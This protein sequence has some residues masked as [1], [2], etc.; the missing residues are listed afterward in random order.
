[1]GRDDAHV[2]SE[3]DVDAMIDTNV[4]G[5]VRV[6]RA[7]VPGMIAR[8]SGD[9]INISRYTQC[10]FACYWLAIYEGLF[11]ILS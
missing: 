6:T 9:I 8:G 1:M 11:F 4:K 10:P 2:V 5:L 3:E 7:V